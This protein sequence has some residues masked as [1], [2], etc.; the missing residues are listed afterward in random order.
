MER[1]ASCRPAI[2]PSVRVSSAAMS[3][4]RE[5][6][7]HHLVEKFGGFGGGEAQVG[8]AQFGQLAPGA[9]AG[10]GQRWVFTGGDDQV[11]L[12]RQVLEQKG[13]GLVNRFGINHMVIIQDEDEIV[14]DGGNFIEQGCQQSIRWAAAEGIGAQPTPLLQYFG[15][16]RLQSSDEV[17]QKAGGV[18]I[19]FVQRQPGDR[20]L[21]TGDPFAD[22]RGFAK[23]GGG[24]DEGQFASCRALV[25][26]LDQ[27]G[28]EDNF[29][30]RWGNIKFGEEKWLRHSKI[31]YTS[32]L[33]RA[34]G[35]K[36]RKHKKGLKNDLD[37][38]TL[39]GYS[40][41]IDQLLLRAGQ[42]RTSV[43]RFG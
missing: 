24:R 37:E 5:V 20:S 35:Y 40:A 17:S 10:Q 25:Q 21:A 23:A 11:H 27:A 6:Q 38:P 8:G 2:Q 26:P 12:R 31:N 32:R 9:Q 34:G 33:I 39:T 36:Q 4:A 22:Q 14:R 28:A 3:S 43:R 16:N 1:A 15:C 41:H 13:E 18:V 7:P 30:P 42:A 19:P 29:R